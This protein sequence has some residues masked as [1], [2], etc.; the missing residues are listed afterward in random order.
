M[1]IAKHPFIKINHI[2]ARLDFLTQEW[3]EEPPGIERTRVWIYFDTKMTAES[4]Y[5]TIV[6]EFKKIEAQVDYL[7]EAKQKKVI[8]QRAEKEK[9][10]ESLSV[11]LRA[12]PDNKGYS[13]G[14]LFFDDNGDTW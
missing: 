6:D 13:I 4:A 2:G 10:W 11:V 8:V 9:P 3:P 7:D 5:S 14:I 12:M 1:Q